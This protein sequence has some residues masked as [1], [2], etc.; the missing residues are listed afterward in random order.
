MPLS[1]AGQA[2]ANQT[3]CPSSVGVVAILSQICLSMLAAPR[4]VDSC[5]GGSCKAGLL[6]H[7]WEI[8]FAGVGACVC[9]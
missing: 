5:H 9:V 7:I 6:S 2:G 4:E 8:D 1:M 3:L